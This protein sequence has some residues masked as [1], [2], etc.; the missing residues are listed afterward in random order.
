M[1]RL[2]YPYQNWVHISRYSVGYQILRFT[3]YNEE[4]CPWR[5]LISCPMQ[6]YSLRINLIIEAIS[7]LPVGIPRGLVIHGP[8][9]V[10]AIPGLWSHNWHINQWAL[11]ASTAPT[12]VPS[13]K[14]HTEKLYVYSLPKRVSPAHIH[15]IQSMY[16]SLEAHKVV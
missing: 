8:L 14:L 12:I 13:K 10:H 9:V 4:G 1:L 15:D 5:H 7:S 16:R 3:T 6:Q 11:A 2:A